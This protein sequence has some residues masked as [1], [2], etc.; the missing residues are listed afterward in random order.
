MQIRIT[1]E[2]TAVA[3]A[4]DVGRLEVVADDGIDLATALRGLGRPDGTDHVW[5]DVVALEQAARAALPEGADVEAWRAAY[6]AM[7]TFADEHG[8]L[9]AR[10]AHV[11]AHV[12]PPPAPR[13]G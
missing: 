5:L 11:R 9:D 1:S 7:I 6:A 10:R 3:E 2:T 12:E 4:A 8:W 13:T